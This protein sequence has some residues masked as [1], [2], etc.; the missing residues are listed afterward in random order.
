MPRC[1]LPPASCSACPRSVRSPH[2]GRAGSGR[3]Y[4]APRGRSRR[5]GRNG[6]SADDRLGHLTAS[7]AR[8]FGALIDCNG[9]LGHRY[10][11]HGEGPEQEAAALAA[12][13]APVCGIGG[14]VHEVPY[15]ARDGV[16]RHT[17]VCDTAF[18]ESWL[19]RPEFRMVR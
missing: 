11:P 8:R 19:R 18:M 2:P 1:A 13:R 10:G 7:P 15:T 16:V 14:V 5:H 9:L 17:H 6:R 12:A 3:D 4:S